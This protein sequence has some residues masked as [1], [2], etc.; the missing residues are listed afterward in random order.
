MRVVKH[1]YLLTRTPT[2]NM[3]WAKGPFQLW[4]QTMLA[5]DM[6]VVEYTDWSKIHSLHSTRSP[7]TKSETSHWSFELDDDDELGL[8]VNLEKVETTLGS[9]P[10]KCRF[11]RYF[12]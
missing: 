9:N 11:V 6:K 7:A 12:L 2:K 10:S 3:L 8:P 5:S 4:L 1:H